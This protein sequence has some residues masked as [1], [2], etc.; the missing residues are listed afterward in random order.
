MKNLKVGGA[1][2]Q[3]P[4]EA[5]EKFEIK[6]DLEGSPA[7]WMYILHRKKNVQK[8]TL[9][10]SCPFLEAT[11]IAIYSSLL[12]PPPPVSQR[13]LYGWKCTALLNFFASPVHCCFVLIGRKQHALT[14]G[15]KNV[16][17][18]G[19]ATECERKVGF[20]VERDLLQKYRS[21]KKKIVAFRF[22]KNRQR[23]R[24]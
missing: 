11:P 20:E 9:C 22:F 12:S 1:G 13:L 3:R 18:A 7:I 21:L 16:D 6:S 2:G 4:L 23:R 8:S 10:C 14:C 15:S 5:E 19:D 17:R 24:N